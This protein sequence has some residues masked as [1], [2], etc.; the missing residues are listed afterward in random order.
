MGRAVDAKK[1][2]RLGKFR[3]FILWFS[4]PLLLSSMAIFSAKI[5]FPDINV[6]QG[7]IYAYITYTVMG[8]LY[9]LVNIPYGS[10]APR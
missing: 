9:S 8:T 1:P 7:L 6:T 4:L 3:P 10:I 2:G 5:F